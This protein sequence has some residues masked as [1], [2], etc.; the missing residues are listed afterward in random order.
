LGGFLPS[1]SDGLDFFSGGGD[2][3]VGM[4]GSV[5]PLDLGGGKAME[6][7]LGTLTTLIP[8]VGVHSLL[9]RRELACGCCSPPGRREQAER[10]INRD[11]TEEFF[12]HRTSSVFH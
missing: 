4:H 10:R 6:T 3:P 9:E 1:G 2:L 8:N 7:A 5:V 11:E 12:C